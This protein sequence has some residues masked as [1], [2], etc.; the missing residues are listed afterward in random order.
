MQRLRLPLLLVACARQS[1]CRAGAPPNARTCGNGST[2]GCRR[3]VDTYQ[4]GNNELL[5]SGYSWHTPWTWTAEKRAE[6]NAN[7]WGGGWARSTSSARTA[8]PTP[9]IFLVFS[10]SH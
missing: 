7:A 5:V 8:T 1:R 9:S 10:D 4:N 6:E 2:R 3:L